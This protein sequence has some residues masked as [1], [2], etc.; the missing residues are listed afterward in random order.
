MGA[1]THNGEG[2]EA[3]NSAGADDRAVGG[4][5]TEP[6]ARD[7]ETGEDLVVE[8]TAA[9]GEQARGR[10]DRARP[11]DDAGESVRKV[12]GQ[13]KG[14][15]DALRVGG[16]F[17]HVSEELVRRVDGGRLVAGQVEE[18][19]VADALAEN[20]KGARG[21]LVTVGDDIADKLAVLIEGGP[22][23]AP[24]VNGDRAGVRELLEGLLQ[25][26]DR[27]GLHRGH[28]PREGAVVP[29]ARLVL[30]TVDVRD[31]QAAIA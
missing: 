25:A 20:V 26:D 18:L 28:V 1:T 6:A 29:A 31:I 30:K 11:A 12:V 16:V 7:T 14:R 21:A 24:R 17:L 23:H 8:V 10:G 9:R 2:F 22:V 15:G 5:F 13:E 19:T 4:E 3:G 27:L